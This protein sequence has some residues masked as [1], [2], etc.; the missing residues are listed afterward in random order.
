MPAT[1]TQND[2]NEA[3][4]LTIYVKL[5]DI[6]FKARGG[7]S[8]YFMV[9]LTPRN[10]LTTDDFEHTKLWHSLREKHA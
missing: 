1:G 5:C 10:K 6:I 4:Y 3:G 2:E 7:R 8:E 9:A